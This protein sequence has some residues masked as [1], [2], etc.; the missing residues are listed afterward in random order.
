MAMESVLS[1]PHGCVVLLL[2]R[3]D[4]PINEEWVQRRVF[5]SRQWDAVRPLPTS[6]TTFVDIFCFSPKLQTE[7]SRQAPTKSTYSCA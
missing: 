1:V 2:M 5:I 7:G 4:P 6:T 3:G